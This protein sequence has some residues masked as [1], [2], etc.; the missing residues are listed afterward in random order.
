MPYKLG[1]IMDMYMVPTGFPNGGRAVAATPCWSEHVWPLLDSRRTM[2]LSRPC[3]DCGRVT[4]PGHSR[5]DPCSRLV[6]RRWDRQSILNRRARMKSGDGGAARLRRKI[7]REGGAYCARCGV[8]YPAPSVEVDHLIPVGRGG[9]DTDD[10]VRPLCS[11]CHYAKSKGEQ[12]PARPARPARGV[13]G[14]QSIMKTAGRG[15]PLH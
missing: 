8:E 7:N 5:C 15:H 6:R 11:R 10:N 1:P 14:R 13:G 12:G 2:L 4:R 9:L 3:L